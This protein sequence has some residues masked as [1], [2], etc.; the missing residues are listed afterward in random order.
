LAKKYDKL[1]NILITHRKG[2]KGSIV[3]DK[4]NYN[5]NN[6]NVLMEVLGTDIYSILG[7]KISNIA[8]KENNM[9]HKIISLRIF[10]LFFEHT[11]RS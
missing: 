2:W 7:F 1:V 6:T 10:L 11:M 9:F 3:F 8:I 4:E 5:P